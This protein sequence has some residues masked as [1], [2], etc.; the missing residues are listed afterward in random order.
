[1]ARVEKI[2]TEWSRDEAQIFNTR[3]GYSRRCSM[4]IEYFPRLIPGCTGV[5]S[6]WSLGLVLI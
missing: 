4:T 5:Q 6:G 3:Q 1:M 2:I